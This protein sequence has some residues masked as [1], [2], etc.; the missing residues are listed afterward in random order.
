MTDWFSSY[1]TNNPNVRINAAPD[2]PSV[3]PRSEFLVPS[4]P[5]HILSSRNCCVTPESHSFSSLQ[6]EQGS[7]SIAGDSTQGPPL[8]T[9]KSHA[10]ASDA[11]R[12]LEDRYTKDLPPTLAVPG[13][14][15]HSA[16]GAVGESSLAAKQIVTSREPRIPFVHERGGQTLPLINATYNVPSEGEPVC[17]LPVANTSPASH[18]SHSRV[19]APLGSPL[20]VLTR[21]QPYSSSFSRAH[22]G[23]QQT[24]SDSEETTAPSPSRSLWESSRY[25]PPSA[26][27]S[28]RTPRTAELI[29]GS[30]RRT[31]MPLPSIAISPPRASVYEYL[32]DKKLASELPTGRNAGFADREVIRVSRPLHK[33]YGALDM[34]NYARHV[35]TQSVYM[36]S[37]ARKDRHTRITRTTRRIPIQEDRTGLDISFDFT[38]GNDIMDSDSVGEG[39]NND[40]QEITPGRPSVVL[41]PSGRRSDRSET[42]ASASA[43][44]SVKPELEREPS[45]PRF[46]S[47]LDPHFLLDS[48]TQSS[49][50]RASSFHTAQ[51]DFVEAE[52]PYCVRE[53]GDEKRYTHNDAGGGSYAITRGGPPK[54]YLD[55]SGTPLAAIAGPGAQVSRSRGRPHHGTQ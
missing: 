5:R 7:F 3:R 50:S 42:P 48:A 15:G 51:E 43:P 31:Q 1:Y 21:I 39:L 44:A 16:N 19:I 13:P 34:Q 10:K 2:T 23:T 30:P 55:L 37:H 11:F 22:Y 26:G 20:P 35:P 46:A 47:G 18:I 53:F 33:P 9:H 49:I 28:P 41:V 17:F 6:G 12:F 29:Q 54:L 24:D 52:H 40:Q 32:Q 25:S 38:S 8:I 4:F 14:R 27:M 45:G 36:Q